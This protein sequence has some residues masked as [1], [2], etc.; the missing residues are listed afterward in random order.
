MK[1]FRFFSLV[2]MFFALAFNAM[3]Q[4]RLN[5]VEQKA[6]DALRDFFRSKNRAYN[7]DAQDNSVLF[8]EGDVVYWVTFKSVSSSSPVILYTIHRKGVRYEKEGTFKASCVYEACNEVN[9]A[10]HVVKAICKDKEVS[11][12]SEMYAKN[13]E[14]FYNVLDFNVDAFKGVAETYKKTYAAAFDAWEKDSIAQNAPQVVEQPIGKSELTVSSVSF[15]SRD[16]K[17]NT[18]VEYD[19]PLRK[20]S[21]N[22]IVAEVALE[23]AVKGVYKI[24]MKIYNPDGKIM[25]PKAGLDYTTTKNFTLP[26]A[27]TPYG[28]ELDPY[29]SDSADTWKAG[30]YKVEIYDCEKGALLKTE[31]FNIL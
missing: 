1:T 27:K 14:D 22:C 31:T 2:V 4:S 19:S 30:E 25:L 12:Y 15:C 17:G 26:K 18:L 13:P 29:G 24:G 21:V 28:V 7:I 20:S 16:T 11:F 23:A 3:A 9:R 8:K 6:Q 10:N 5:D